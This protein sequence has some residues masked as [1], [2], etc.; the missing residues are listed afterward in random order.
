[1]LRPLRFLLPLLKPYHRLASGAH[2][3]LVALVV[4]DLSIPRLVQRIIDQGIRAQN[5]TVVLQTGL[6]MLVISLFSLA[7]AVGNNILS[8]KVSEGVVRDL[9]EA[10]FLK[11]QQLSFGNLD[12]M[13]T[14][15]L[16]VRLSSDT[17]AIRR[18]VSI[19][20]RIGARAPLLMLGSFILMVRTSPSLALMLL[21]LILVA[22]GVICW[23]I[24]RME[25]LFLLVQQK[26][27]RLN[28][29]LQE[30]V[31]GVRLI[32]AFVRAKH[33]GNRFAV[34]N[35]AFTAYSIRILRA[36]SS[37]PPIMTLCVNAGIVL[38]IWF[39]GLA[40]TRGELS[41]GQVVAFTN[42]LLT[43]LAPLAMMA[44]LSNAWANGLASARRVSELLETVPEILDRP[45]A[46]TLP[47]LELGEGPLRISFE[48]VSFRYGNGDRAKNGSEGDWVLR[49][50]DMEIAPGTTTAILGATGSGK[51]TLI[52]LVPRFY[53]AD[54]GRIRINGID[55]RDLR[56]QDLLSLI[57]VVPQET[58]LFSGTVT[59]NIRY[60]NPDADMAEV[61]AA[62]RA[63]QAHDFILKLPEGYLT[64]IEE[65]G[66]NLSGGQRQ[67]L[68]IA[69]ALLT[70][71]RLLILDDSTS[72]LDIDT[73]NR[74]QEALNRLPFPHTRLV[75]AQR[76]ST[77][78]AADTI[79]IL[80]KGRIIGRGSHD[81][82]LRGCAVYQE[83]YASQLGSGPVEETGEMAEGSE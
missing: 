77:V 34:A 24:L 4:L 60:G 47:D 14:G 17:A 40:A 16:M 41:V 21:P 63:A 39:G 19:S 51:S 48:G 25:P 7:M 22:L 37:M 64:R 81:D 54:R 76:V 6:L 15:G 33:E 66:A 71:P 69:R 75:V 32:K 42:Y 50:I 27:D 78:L 18:I 53:E 9:R 3:C 45:D 80:E 79:V 46:R 31:S 11:I 73:E 62:A 29:V 1:M 65:R 56:Q 83:I 23:F 52:N 2:C 67:R 28:T 8:V 30:N 55:I 26:F 82:L 74:L 35:A 61:E 12:R 20:L 72:A 5:H 36:I 58:I 59:D 70:K 10:V 57:A 68:A 43:T 44:M 38:V 13:Q 49:D